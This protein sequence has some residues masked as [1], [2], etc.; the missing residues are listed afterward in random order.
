MGVRQGASTSEFNEKSSRT[1]DELQLSIQLPIIRLDS[2]SVSPC[3]V[4]K[5]IPGAPEVETMFV[6]VVKAIIDT[7][8]VKI[9][10]MTFDLTWQCFGDVELLYFVG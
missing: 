1:V 2:F 10:G 6:L 4:T 3:N 5:E 8:V 7:L 9:P